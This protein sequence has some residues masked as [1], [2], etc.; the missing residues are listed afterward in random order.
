MQ[1]AILQRSALSPSQLRAACAAKLPNPWG[2]VAAA[3]VSAVAQAA[4]GQL[5][6]AASAYNSDSAP[7][8]LLVDAI[9]AEPDDL[10]LAAAFERTMSNARQLAEAADAASAAQGQKAGKVG[11]GVGGRRQGSAGP[12]IPAA[13]AAPLSP[14]RS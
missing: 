7:H 3:H 2:S 1:Q 12:C 13:G 5:D 6:A 14:P 4:D 9:N 10:G 11:G 8:L